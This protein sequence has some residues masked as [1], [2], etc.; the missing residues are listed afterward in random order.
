MRGG[1]V[2]LIVEPQQPPAWCMG[3][4]RH[5]AANAQ[6]SRILKYCCWDFVFFKLDSHAPLLH[7][8]RCPTPASFIVRLPSS[9]PGV[10]ASLQYLDISNNMLTGGCPRVY[11]NGIV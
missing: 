4:E 10:S 11:P 9:L 6:D 5:Q 1:G 8:L 3:I 7:P 2:D